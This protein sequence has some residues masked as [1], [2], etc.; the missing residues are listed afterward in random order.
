M[1]RPGTPHI[2][3]SGPVVTEYWDLLVL[4]DEERR[5]RPKPLGG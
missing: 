2:Q 4:W 3:E 5:K 1:N